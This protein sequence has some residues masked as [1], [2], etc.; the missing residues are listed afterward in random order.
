MNVDRLRH[1]A[2]RPL[3]A[4]SALLLWCSLVACGSEGAR[5]FGVVVICLD[6]VRFDTFWLPER[7]G[8]R[9]PF[10]PWAERALRFQRALA[11]AP[12][13]LPSVASLFTGRYPNAHGAGSYLGSSGNLSSDVPPPL[14]DDV[15]TL[16]ALLA[17]R[18]YRVQGFVAQAFFKPAFGLRRGFTGFRQHPKHDALLRMAEEWLDRERQAG[19]P[20]LLYLHFL[21]A[22]REH[23]QSEELVRARV[24]AMRD[25][26]RA[27]AI[28]AA[29]ADACARPD[30]HLCRVYLSYVGA[31]LKLRRAVAGLLERLEERGLLERTIV[32]LYSDH[33]EEFHDHRAEQERRGTDARGIHGFGHGQSLYQELLHVPLLVWHP[34]IPGADVESQVNLVDVAPTLAEWLDLPNPGIDWDGR[35]L[36]TAEARGPGQARPV[37]AS[38]VAF[39]P[40]EVAVVS[41]RWKRLRRTEPEER[42]LFD[43]ADDPGE[44]EPR[45][46][47]AVERELDA[48]ID[49]YRAAA[50][51]PG[52]RA[53]EVSGEDL[54]ALRALG[55]VQELEP[56]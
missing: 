3:R 55:Y 49:R 36:A 2:Q 22:H 53:A 1:R 32:V 51:P 18:G 5:P 35:S 54:E 37:F 30:E 10:S 45:S 56:E 6:T 41:G 24:A 21:E 46:D 23:M 7:A 31:V 19:E 48:L 27:A 25:W 39:G 11:P 9:D 38:E 15:P 26:V 29:P 16:P 28:A 50:R 47:P 43:L 52:A 13:T 42:L 33:G 44:R 8:L 14:A 4:G 40:A 20:F 17:G 34:A 12:W